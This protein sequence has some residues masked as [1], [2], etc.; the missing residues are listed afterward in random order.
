MN[1]FQVAYQRAARQS[2]THIHRNPVADAFCDLLSSVHSGD[3]GLS[4]RA[5]I[6]ALE[7]EM[8]KLPQV[9]QPVQHFF[10]DKLYGRV[11]FNPKDSFIVTK[12]H[13]QENIST[14]ISGR[15]GVISENGLEVIEAPKVF[16]TKPGT[17]RVLYAQTDVLFS[18]VHQNPNDLRDL[19]A[20]EDQIIAKSF[21][22]IE[23]LA[24]EA[25]Q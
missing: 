13:K 6:E 1:D 24:Q 3:T 7:A 18:T 14:L 8:D 19:D 5:K 2:V 11:I 22:E 9:E 23:T 25:L 15:L 21:A 10:A 16:V 17:K 12:I 4:V 20:L